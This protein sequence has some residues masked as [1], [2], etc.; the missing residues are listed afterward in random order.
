ME[1][2]EIS[3]FTELPFGENIYQQA[4]ISKIEDG[5]DYEILSE[6]KVLE[7]IDYINLTAVVKILAEFFDVNCTAIA[8]E[9]SICAVA[10]GSTL[11]NSFE[12]ALDCDPLS[13]Y[14]GTLGFTKPVTLELVKELKAVKVRN[15]LAPKYSDEALKYLQGATEINIIKINTPMQEILG[16]SAKDIKVTPFGILVQEQNHSKLTKD[17]FKVVTKT[18]PTQEQAEDAIFAWKVSKHLKSQSAVIAKGLSTKAIIQG[19]PNGAVTSELAMD[20][21][22]ENSKEAVLSL[23]G[24][25]ENKET[26]NAAIQGRIGLIIDAGDSEYS[27]EIFKLADKYNISIISTKIRNNKY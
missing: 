3:E 26:I 12:K 22:C 1:K 8:K 17:S 24:V 11:E 9:S 25:I 20:Y 10:L 4:S 19:K 27:K 5:I 2:I 7:Y 15:I 21:A 13:A 6:N 16:F 14:K 23:D 18:K